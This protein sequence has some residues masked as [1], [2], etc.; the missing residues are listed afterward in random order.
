MRSHRRA[1]LAPVHE[2]ED[3]STSDLALQVL[4]IHTQEYWQIARECYKLIGHEA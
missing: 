1:K 2:D 4:V 3:I